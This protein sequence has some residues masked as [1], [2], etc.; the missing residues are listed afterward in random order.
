[1]R[2]GMIRL[3]QAYAAGLERRSRIV[4]RVLARRIE[5]ILIAWLV[6][7]MLGS[8]PKLLFAASPVNGPADLAA[9]ALPY[10]L[11][12]SAPLAGYL[13]AAAFCP[14]GRP[15]PA[16]H[17]R[18]SF[19]GKWRKLSSAS[20][21]ASPLYGPSGFL[22]SLLIGLL[23]NVVVRSGEF[24]VAVPAINGHAPAW[25]QQLF[26]IMSADVIVMS[27]FYTVC[28]VMALRAAPLFPRMLLYCWTLD[29][30][31]QLIIA[32]QVGAM[33]GVPASVSGALLTLLDGNVTK[34]L[35]SVAVWLPYLILSER[36]NVTYRQ[37]TSLTAG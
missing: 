4:P 23:L 30:A 34:V 35:I 25:G 8:L 17:T 12:A 27:F 1:M 11:I 29:V 33:R 19:Y 15:A 32:Q 18:L 13:L 31:A 28:F 26:L 21:Q 20:A 10:L 14:A 2:R 6:A 37:R 7:V 3:V 16:T 36:V 5:P 9:L 22:A 24:M